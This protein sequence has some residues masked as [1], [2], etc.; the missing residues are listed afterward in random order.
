MSLTWLRWLVVPL[1]MLVQLSADQ[2][3]VEALRGTRTYVVR[4]KADQAKAEVQRS[5]LTCETP[6]GACRLSEKA[7]SP[8]GRLLEGRVGSSLASEHRT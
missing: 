3:S 7:Y 8:L 5:A 1:T 6:Q 4:C 2:A